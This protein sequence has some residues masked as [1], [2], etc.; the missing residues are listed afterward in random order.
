MMKRI[1]LALLSLLFA[2]VTIAHGQTLRERWQQRQRQNQASKAETVQGPG[3]YHLSL[4]FGGTERHYLVHV[5]RSYDAAH[6]APLL[7]A[8]HGGG[9]NMDLQADDQRYGLIKLSEKYGIVAVFPNGIGALGGDKLATWNAGNCCG[10]SRDQAVDDV[11]FLRAVL[12][13]VEAQ[14]AIDKARVYATGMS[15]GGMMAQRLAC[16]AADVFTAVAPVAGTDNTRQCSPTR[17]VSII[18]FHA[19]D[20]DHVLFKGGAGEKAFPNRA[21]VTDFTSVPETI[22]RWVQ[23]NQCSAKAEKVLDVPGAH[24]EVHSGCQDGVTVE[25]CVTDTGGHS[26][27]GAANTRMGKS[28]ASQAISADELMWAFFQRR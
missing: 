4:Q 8:L 2:W 28:P 17:P 25:L 19:L 23:R 12:A 15:N 11:G 9:G 13:D 26:W 27:P 3:D 10:K 16:D 20:D 24:C 6:L 21:Q 14:L 7:M 1:S 18:E 5:P 22:A